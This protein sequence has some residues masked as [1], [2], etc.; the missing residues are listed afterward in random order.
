MNVDGAPPAAGGVVYPTINKVNV[1]RVNHHTSWSPV[2]SSY[3]YS[4]QTG[5]IYHTSTTDFE[6]LAV[7]GAGAVNECHWGHTD[8]SSVSHHTQV[9]IDGV[10]VYG[11]QAAYDNY[12]SGNKPNHDRNYE[13]SLSPAVSYNN[14]QVSGTLSHPITFKRSFVIKI[15][16]P[17]A[18]KSWICYASITKFATLP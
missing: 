18:N 3:G 15:M 9:L 10:I 17:P 7:Q 2:V 16:A 5:S 12:N 11:T 8:S 14:T 13:W 1:A 6:L 4:I